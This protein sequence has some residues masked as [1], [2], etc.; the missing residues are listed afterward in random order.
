MI[1]TITKS[2]TV[3]TCRERALVDM[4]RT[5]AEAIRQHRDEGYMDSDIHAFLG[6]HM[7]EDEQAA[8]IFIDE[9]VQRCK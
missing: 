2:A 4:V 6:M 5:L 8:S 1:D 7:P 3:L 9:Y